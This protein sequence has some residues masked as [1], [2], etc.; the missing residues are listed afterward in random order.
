MEAEFAELLLNGSH[1]LSHCLLRTHGRWHGFYTR[2]GG[3]WRDT[4]RHGAAHGAAH[5]A[6][7]R[8]RAPFSSRVDVGLRLTFGVWFS[9]R[10]RLRGASWKTGLVRGGTRVTARVQ[11]RLQAWVVGECGGTRVV[12]KCPGGRETGLKERGNALH[13]CAGGGARWGR[14]ARAQPCACCHGYAKSAPTT[15]HNLRRSHCALASHEPKGG[16]S[17]PLR[18]VHGQAPRPQCM[19]RI[20]HGHCLTLSYLFF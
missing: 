11:T 6:G 8:D 14:L 13:W 19:K 9:V 15:N 2:T 20:V 17:L 10:V 1:V 18:P 4:W 7:G 16:R 5:A 3:A 12:G